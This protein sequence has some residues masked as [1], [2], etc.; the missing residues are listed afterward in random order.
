MTS[1]R[2]ITNSISSLGPSDLP[3]ALIDAFSQR[4]KA[5][6]WRAKKTETGTVL[7]FILKETNKTTD[8]KCAWPNHRIRALRTIY[9][10]T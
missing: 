2:D 3:Y 10:I 8:S 9:I 5:G 7:A 1:T 6:L 4:K